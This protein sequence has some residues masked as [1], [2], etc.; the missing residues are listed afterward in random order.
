MKEK[1]LPPQT[2][3]SPF[4]TLIERISL[5]FVRST[6]VTHPQSHINSEPT[7]LAVSSF[8]IQGYPPSSSFLIYLV[9]IL[10]QVPNETR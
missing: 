2:Y 7:F 10:N 5:S 1:C 4:D 9:Y 8:C 6:M 3:Y